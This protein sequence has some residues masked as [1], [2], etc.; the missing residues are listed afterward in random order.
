MRRAGEAPPL[1][2]PGDFVYVIDASAKV[3]GAEGT[4]WRTDDMS[5]IV[6]VAGQMKEE[7]DRSAIHP[8]QVIQKRF[9]S[10]RVAE[11]IVARAVIT[12]LGYGDQLGDDPD[13]EDES[14]DEAES[15][16]EKAWV[17][18]LRQHSP[19]SRAGSER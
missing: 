2:D 1:S 12:D 19:H 17:G 14:E 15:E 10:R 6:E 18:F 8:L 9:E 3:A 11:S 4:N 13:M 5:R 16:E 7:V